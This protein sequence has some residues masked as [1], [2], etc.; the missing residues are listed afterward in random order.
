MS[1]PVQT[2]TIALLVIVA[3]VASAGVVLALDDGSSSNQLTDAATQA[4]S[5]IT[6]SS[7]G[8][9]RVQPDAAVVRVSIEA[10]DPDVTAARTAVA[11]NVSDVRSALEETGLGE[12]Q[13][14]TSEYRIYEDRRHDPTPTEGERSTEYRVRQTLTIEMNQI[15]RTGAVIDA[16]VD[17]G[18]TGI[19]DVRYTLSTETRQEMKNQA[20]EN[21]M[22]DARSQAETV[23]ESG[24]LTIDGV[25]SVETGNSGVPRPVYAMETA[26][27][28]QASTD[29]DAGPVTVAAHVTVTYNA[30]S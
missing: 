17:A 16:A 21:A 27:D 26:A 18:A 29:I 1:R 24:D 2:L 13:V 8:E 28:G 6:V 22:S 25:S 5:T 3:V 15:D 7:T 12:D 23:A 14:H 20:L 4:P 30:S 9:E 10:T 11:E 19:H